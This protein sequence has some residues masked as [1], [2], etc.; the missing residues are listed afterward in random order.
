MIFSNYSEIK[1]LKFDLIIIGGGPAGITIAL[2]LEKKKI[3]SLIIEA[4]KYNFS[5]ESQ[6]FYEGSIIGDEYPPLSV[7]R[8]RQFGG[9]T[10]HWG[11]VC[12]SLE[13]HDFENWPIKKDLDIYAD[14]AKKVINL[15]RNNFYKK[16]INADFDLV[17]FEVSPLRFRD[18]YKEKIKDS[19]YIHLITESY[20]TKLSGDKKISEILFYNK[21]DYFPLKSKYFVLASGGIENSKLMHLTRKNN[22]KLLNPKMPIGNYFL[23]HPYNK[24]GEVIIDIENFNKLLKKSLQDKIKLNC[25][26]KLLAANKILSKIIIY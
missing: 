11:G 17:K 3:S 2:E 18:K 1:D 5:D 7:T 8:L 23:E 20:V 21:G 9:S 4:G 6:K 13:E 12:R 22:P 24:I 10:G 16:K 25:D 19:K 15:K 26:Y 14:T